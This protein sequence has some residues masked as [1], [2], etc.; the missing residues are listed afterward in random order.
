MSRAPTRHHSER[1]V[2]DGHLPL[3]KCEHCTQGGC[4]A[5]REWMAS[6]VLQPLL[7]AMATAHEEVVQSA[8]RLGWAGLQLSPLSEAGASSSGWLV[9]DV[10]SRCQGALPAAAAIHTT[11]A[12]W[13]LQGV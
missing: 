5:L 2:S 4:E 8:A 13:W 6:D 3:L 9:A 10:M 7:L 11:C 12:R 1:V